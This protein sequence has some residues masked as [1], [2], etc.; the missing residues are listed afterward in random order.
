MKLQ[1]LKNIFSKDITICILI[2]A[3]ILAIGSVLSA[4]VENEAEPLIEATITTTTL[5]SP[6]TQPSTTTMLG[7]SSTVITKSHY[8]TGTIETLATQSVSIAPI[9]TKPRVVLEVPV[10]E[11]VKT[12]SIKEAGELRETAAGR[13]EAAEGLLKSAEELGSAQDDPIIVYAQA[14]IKQCKEAVEYYDN[15]IQELDI[16]YW[17]SK[18]EE[19]PIATKIWRYMKNLGWND[20]VCAGIMGNIMTECGGQTLD[21]KYW[22][23]DSTGHYYGICQWYDKYFPSVQGANLPTQLNF[24][25]DT[26]ESQMNDWGN[27][28]KRGFNYEKFLQLTDAGDAALAFAKCY[29]R[30]NSKH[31]AVRKDNALVAYKYF[32]EGR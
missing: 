12:N 26:I 25:R 31:Y 1:K 30:C 18:E 24:L 3:T 19:Y 6:T 7:T 17:L 13:L 23:Y 4:V 29:E 16:A 2:I 21:I 11:L 8:L 20:Y 27:S 28:Y 22:I 14:E 15:L 5:N 9:T 10:I 32:T